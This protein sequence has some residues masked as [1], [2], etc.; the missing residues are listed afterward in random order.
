LTWVKVSAPSG[1]ST[2]GSSPE[3]NEMPIETYLVIAGLVVVFGAFIAV[4]AWGVWYTKDI[5]PKW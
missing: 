5:T 2:C 1:W 3:K 4:L